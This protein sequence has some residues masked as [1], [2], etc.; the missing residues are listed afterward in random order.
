MMEQYGMMGVPGLGLIGLLVV[1]AIAGYVASRATNMNNSM[2][3]N[4]VVGII[5]AI[6]GNAIARVLGFLVFGWIAHIATAIL[7]SVLVLYV[8]RRIRN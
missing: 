6:V 2:L 5:G 1:G 3:T 8:W 4:I 7:G